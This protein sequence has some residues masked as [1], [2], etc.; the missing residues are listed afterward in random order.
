MCEVGCFIFQPQLHLT[1]VH[2]AF[3]KGFQPQGLVCIF[4]G[5]LVGTH[6]SRIANRFLELDAFYHLHLSTK[7]STQGYTTH[8]RLKAAVSISDNPAKRGYL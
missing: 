7:K 6:K 1:N 8:P 4:R 2:A 3:A 5:W